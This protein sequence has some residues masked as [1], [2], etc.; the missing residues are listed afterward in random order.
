M[1]RKKLWR[2]NINL[3]L[4]EGAKA[5]MDSLLKDGEDRLDLIR[6]AIERELERREREQSKD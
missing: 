3:T 4:P 2:E 1:G 6:A 5:R